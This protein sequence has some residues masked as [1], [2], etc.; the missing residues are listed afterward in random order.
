MFLSRNAHGVAL[1][2][3]KAA[4]AYLNRVWVQVR[5]RQDTFSPSRTCVC[6]RLWESLY[7]LAVS[8]NKCHSWTLKHGSAALAFKYLILSC[9]WGRGCDLHAPDKL[10]CCGDLIKRTGV[11]LSLS[12]SFYLSLSLH[13]RCS[14]MPQKLWVALRI[15][16]HGSCGKWWRI[17]PWKL[18]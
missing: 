4:A 13:S 7:A 6:G 2:L 8:L 16:M 14:I 18:F 11:S 10:N 5:E 15:H 1:S 9:L 3:H 12:V 17:V